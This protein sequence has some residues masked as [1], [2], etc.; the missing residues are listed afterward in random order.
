MP[1]R[2]YIR[3]FRPADLKRI[4]EIEL[5][6]FSDEP[7]TEEIFL[8]LARE[9]AGLFLVATLE[10]RV[11][12]YIATSASAAKAEIISIAVAPDCRRLGTGKALMQ[13]TLDLLARSGIRTVSLTVR[14]E[15]EDAIRFYR[16][17]GFRRVRAI[18]RYYQDGGAGLRMRLPLA[19]R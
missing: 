18:P 4:L 3:R 14:V 15:N 8:D 1:C 2:P 5:A 16:C 6:A 11:V 13:H 10:R 7:Y 9:C 12:A 19:M 17:F